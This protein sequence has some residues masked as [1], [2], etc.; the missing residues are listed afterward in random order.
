MDLTPPA[1]VAEVAETAEVGQQVVA[2]V[3]VVAEE[4]VALEGV[5]A[6]LD[7]HR[8]PRTA[9]SQPLPARARLRCRLSST[10]VPDT[11]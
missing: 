10:P 8:T 11:A 3:A 5:V 1:A 9:R 6:E 2:E 7:Q 4:E